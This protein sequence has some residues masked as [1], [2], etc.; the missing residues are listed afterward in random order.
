MSHWVSHWVTGWDWG[1][2]ERRLWGYCQKSGSCNQVKAFHSQG[3]FHKDGGKRFS[4]KGNRETTGK[5]IWGGIKK[6]LRQ[7]QPHGL[8]VKFGTLCFSSPGSVPRCGPILRV[9]GHAVAVTHIQNR[10]SFS[11]MLAQGESSSAEKKKKKAKKR[12]FKA[13]V[14]ISLG[15]AWL[16]I[17]TSLS[18][19]T[20]LPK[21]A[22]LIFK[23]THSM[24]P[25]KRFHFYIPKMDFKIQ[26]N[27]QIM[28]SQLCI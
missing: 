4:L 7:G 17:Y 10:G 18:L 12:K 21:L 27:W 3:I 2:R 28:R 9:G 25:A 8:V 15:P 1:V 24:F 14:A 16:S 22:A 5:R 11:W 20:S 19:S 23:R 26:R 13:K 6:Y